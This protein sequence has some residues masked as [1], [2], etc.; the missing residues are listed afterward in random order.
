M[1]VLLLTFGPFVL[2]GGKINGFISGWLLLGRRYFGTGNLE[3][4]S[5][6]SINQKEVTLPFP[7]NSTSPLSSRSNVPNLSKIVFVASETCILKAAKY[8]LQ[9]SINQVLIILKFFSHICL[10]NS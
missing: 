5:E 2:F 1:N 9:S 10:E 4:G 8:S 7:F 6:Q 3:S